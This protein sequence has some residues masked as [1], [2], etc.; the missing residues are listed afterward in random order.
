MVGHGGSSAGSYLANPTSTIPSHCVV[1]ILCP[2]ASAV[3]ASTLGVNNYLYHL[4]TYY[5]TRTIT[6]ILSLSKNIIN[7]YILVYTSAV[8]PLIQHYWLG[9]RPQLQSTRTKPLHCS[10]H[11]LCSFKPCNTHRLSSIQN[12]QQLPK[13]NHPHNTD[14]AESWLIS[15]KVKQ[16]ITQI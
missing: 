1:I 2:S 14:H 13:P 9:I 10:Q 16:F 5:Y 7:G 8:L 12:T 4:A 11:C 15:S 6:T 3:V